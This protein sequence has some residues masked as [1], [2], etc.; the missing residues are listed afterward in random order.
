MNTQ[1]SSVD[2]NAVH[3]QHIEYAPPP[4]GGTAPP[5]PVRPGKPRWFAMLA[6]ILVLMLGSGLFG[7]WVATR[8]DHQTVVATTA[9]GGTAAASQSSLSGIV[10][11]VQPSVVSIRTEQG[12][13][14]GVVLDRDGY[15][16][17]NNHVVATAA[18]DSVTATFS[19]GTSRPA[20]IVGADSRSDLAVVKVDGAHDLTPAVFGDSGTVQVG[21]EVLA[22]GSP[23]GLEG[24]V[25]SGI[26]SAKNRTIQESG[27]GG[28]STSISGMLQ[29]D[30]AINPGNS[31]GALVDAAGDVIGIDTAIATAGNSNGNIGVGF[32]IPANTAVQVAKQLIEGKQVAH[33]YLGVSVGDVSGG[34]A[35]VQAVTDG[36]PAA[37]AGLRPGDVITKLGDQTID[38][39][40][41]LVAAIQ[42][43]TVGDQL[44]LTYT[45]NGADQHATVTLGNAP[46]V[47]APAH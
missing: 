2:S 22:L 7:G 12:E 24:S 27:E 36:G 8:L 19:N 30:A 44:A 18:G 38:N 28:G 32:A 23:L 35:L 20:A 42:G 29:T 47:Q 15:I 39:S 13:G 45:R 3:P 26:V 1:L 17:T 25:T 46:D 16:L 41:D 34:G 9:S 40:D 6:A 31:G 4:G 37:Q 10:D 11:K 14:S 33:P 43:G 5:T 21:D